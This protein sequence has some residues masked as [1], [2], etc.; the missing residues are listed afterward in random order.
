LQYLIK[1]SFNIFNKRRILFIKILDLDVDS[2]KI[3]TRNIGYKHQA[4]FRGVFSKK[5]TVFSYRLAGI[6]LVGL[7]LPAEDGGDLLGGAT[8]PPVLQRAAHPP[9]RHLLQTEREM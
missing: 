2:Q 1:K 4:N 7:P 9:S 5:K 8:R 6:F 3:F